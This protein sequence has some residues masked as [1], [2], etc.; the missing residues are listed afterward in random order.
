M[1]VMYN[2]IISHNM[3]IEDNMNYISDCQ[4]YY[5]RI[6]RQQRTSQEGCELQIQMTKEIRDKETHHNL[7]QYLVEHIWRLQKNYQHR[8]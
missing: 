7:R 1:R 6:P 3:I 5:T 4:E 8:Q 2:C